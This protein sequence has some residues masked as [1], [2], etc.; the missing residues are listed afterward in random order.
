M[1]GATQFR[2]SDGLG[3]KDKRFGFHGE[4]LFG[5]IR[6]LGFRGCRFRDLG[7]RDLGLRVSGLSDLGI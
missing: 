5:F 4:K 3:F 2:G 1:I 7:L 6:A